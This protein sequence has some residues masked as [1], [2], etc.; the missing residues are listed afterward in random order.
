MCGT[1]GAVRYADS[2]SEAKQIKVYTFRSTGRAREHNAI[3]EILLHHIG[4]GDRCDI[5]AN[6]SSSAV[7]IGGRHN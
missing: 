1:D 6:H 3:D 2:L 4:G 5:D 7:S